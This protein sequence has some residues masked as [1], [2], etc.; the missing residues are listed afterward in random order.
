LES[1]PPGPQPLQE[2]PPERQLRQEP[3]QQPLVWM[4]RLLPP[5]AGWRMPMRL[6]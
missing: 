6:P 2:P 3:G 1:V 5:L 4:Q